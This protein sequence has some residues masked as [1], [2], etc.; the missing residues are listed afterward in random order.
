MSC[1]RVGN[2]LLAKFSTQGASDVCLHIPA[3][4]VFWLIKH[5]P[6]NQDPTLQAPPPPP[7]VTQFDWQNPNNPKAISLNCR[8][9]PGKLR[10]AF[11]LDR[12]PNLVL[13]LDRSNVELLRQI[14]VMY[15]R[16]LIDLDA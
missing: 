4:I 11:N 15:S 12:K 14:L 7:Q 10:M 13:V 6:V 9:L 3:N 2:T 8:E 16:E 1:D 5:L